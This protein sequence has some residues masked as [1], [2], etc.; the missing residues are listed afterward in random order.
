MNKS[1]IYVHIKSE[2]EA[3]RAKEILE[4]WGEYATELDDFELYPYVMLEDDVWDT[5]NIVGNN[6]EI[7][8]DQ[9]DKLLAQENNKNIILNEPV[10]DGKFSSYISPIANPEENVKLDRT[11]RS[12]FEL[13]TILGLNSYESYILSKLL[14]CRKDGTFKK[15]LEAIKETIDTYLEEYKN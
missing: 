14:R 11:F 8:L 9:L 3:K 2:D 4:K 7:T 12:I 5:D 6:I 10:K 1:Q 15:D 13:Q